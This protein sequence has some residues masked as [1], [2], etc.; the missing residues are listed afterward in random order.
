M[1]PRVS[2]LLARP[3]LVQRTPE[4]YEARR[5][6]ITASDCAAALGIKPYASYKGC[7]RSEL[8]TKKLENRPFFNIFVE[9]GNKY[10]DEA[11]DAAMAQLGMQPLDFGLLRHPTLPWLGASPDGVTTCGR[12]IEIKCPL[13]RK[14]VPGEVPHHYVPQV[15]VQMQVCGLDETLFVQY[16]PRVLTGGEPFMDVTRVQRDDAWFEAALPIL[17][18]FFDEYMAARTTFVAEPVPAPPPCLVDPRLYDDF[19]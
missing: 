12:C 6:L 5:E 3:Q 17:K 19:I 14:I 16:R 1:D 2:A 18:G 8:L 9:H 4:W 15:Q 7:P 13:R 11:R 10:E